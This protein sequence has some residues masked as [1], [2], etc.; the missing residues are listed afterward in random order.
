MLKKLQIYIETT[1]ECIDNTNV[2]GWMEAMLRKD[3]AMFK[4]IE[5]YLKSQP[6]NLIE[7]AMEEWIESQDKNKIDNPLIIGAKSYSMVQILDEI[8]QRSTFGISFMKDVLNLTID[9]IARG[10]RKID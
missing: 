4:E 3:L 2:N 10:K 8:R 1:E 6:D 5:E 7:K 9:L